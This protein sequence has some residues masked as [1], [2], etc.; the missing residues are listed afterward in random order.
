M[1]LAAADKA[2][3]SDVDAWVVLCGGG[4]PKGRRVRNPQISPSTIDKIIWYHR[5]SPQLWT[6]ISL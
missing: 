3:V 5:A 1:E 2:H 4:F 6:S